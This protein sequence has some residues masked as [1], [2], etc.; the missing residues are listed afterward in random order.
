MANPQLEHGYTRICNELLEVVIYRINNAAWQKCIFYTIR[1]TYGFKHK[2]VKSNY[3]AYATKTGLTKEAIK[4]ALM[5]LNNRKILEITVISPE[6]FTVSLNKNYDLWE[7][8][9]SFKRL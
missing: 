8:E 4:D 5:D 6:R 3:Q 1:I 2:S 7:I 9:D